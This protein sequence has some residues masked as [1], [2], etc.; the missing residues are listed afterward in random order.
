MLMELLPFVRQRVSVSSLPVLGPSLDDY[1]AWMLRRGYPRRTVREYLRPVCR[2]EGRLIA[3]GVIS[4][5]YLTRE[6]LLACRQASEQRD[7]LPTLANSLDRFFLAQGRFNLRTPTVQEAKAASFG[8]YLQKVR[9]FSPSTIQRYLPKE[10]GY[11]RGEEHQTQSL[12][13]SPLRVLPSKGPRSQIPRPPQLPICRGCGK[14]MC[15]SGNRVCLPDQPPL[16]TFVAT[17]EIFF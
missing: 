14:T 8:E 16:G 7:F 5:V 13:H 15:V 3:M 1:A 12:G 4:D 9:G 11:I 6:A 10:I 2:L 17:R